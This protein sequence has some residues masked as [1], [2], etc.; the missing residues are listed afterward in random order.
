M[1]NKMAKGDIIVCM[2]DDDYYSQERVAHA[3]YKLMSVPNIKIAGS[4]IL[5][6]YYPHIQKIY[7]FGP[8]GTYHGTN[9]TMAYKKS[10]LDEH[11]Y[12]EDATKAEESHFT[13]NFSE[14]MIQLDPIKTMLC[15]AHND[16]IMLKRI[17]DLTEKLKI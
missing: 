4:S 16:K 3:V 6:I 15:I 9:G 1:L 11:H 5:H 2:D 13:N 10:Y 8:Y 12:I 7:K 17:N 14:P